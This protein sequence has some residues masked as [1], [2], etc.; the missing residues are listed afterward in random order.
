MPKIPANDQLWRSSVVRLRVFGERGFEKFQ[1]DDNLRREVL[2]EGDSGPETT[3]SSNLENPPFFQWKVE[4][5]TRKGRENNSRATIF[6]PLEESL[7]AEGVLGRKALLGL[8]LGRE[9]R[10]QRSRVREPKAAR[11]SK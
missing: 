10:L 9:E 1:L 5:T 2:S 7:W 4:T 3:G 8:L 11:F 6:N